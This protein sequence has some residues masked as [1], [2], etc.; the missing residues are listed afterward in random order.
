[1]TSAQAILASALI[2]AAVCRTNAK[3]AAMQ[4]SDQWEL[5]FGVGQ[6]YSETAYAEVVERIVYD[7]QEAINQAME[8]V[9]E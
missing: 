9:S 1:M 5:K 3:I 2:N 7:P 6:I 8:Y 4:S